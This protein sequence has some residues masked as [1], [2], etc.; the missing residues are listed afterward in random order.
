MSRT[1][2]H[3]DL[4]D[5]VEE[6]LHIVYKRELAGRRNALVA[7]IKKKPLSATGENTEQERCR[8][9]RMKDFLLCSEAGKR[10]S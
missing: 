4:S 8:F 10:L 5:E 2:S 6:P 3:R 9:P 7:F 1:P